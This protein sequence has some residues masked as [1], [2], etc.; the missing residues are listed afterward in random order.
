MT[1]DAAM[2]QVDPGGSAP[3]AED[4]RS[5]SLLWLRC[6]LA[7]WQWVIIAF[8]ASRLLIYMLIR[9]SRMILIR[10]EHWLR[11]GV[12]GI[13]TQESAARYLEIA[14]R[15][16]GKKRDVAPKLGLF[17]VY[18]KVVDFFSGIFASEALAGIVVSNAALLAAGILL[19]ELVA[20]EYK[21]ERLSRAAVAFLMFGPVSFF[22]SCAVPEALFLALVLAA[23]LAAVKGRWLIAS[24][25][26][27]V[28]SA[29]TGIGVLILI[30]LLHLYLGSGDSGAAETRGRPRRNGLFLA[31]VPLG[32][33]AFLLY[34]EVKYDKSSAP[35]ENAEMW[36]SGLL[37]PWQM[38]AALRA[39]PPFFG[40]FTAM[41]LGSAA[42]LWFAG[43]RWK[44]RPAYLIYGAIL[45]IACACTSDLPSI[46]R[47]L[48]VAFPLYIAAA[49][50][51]E[52]L[53]WAYEPLLTCSFTALA[54]CT[55]M[56]ANGH[57]AK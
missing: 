18:P 2:A 21:N 35:F 33:I 34:S 15:G 30:P 36:R 9:L 41:V 11:E 6:L 50:A 52:R 7:R 51:S 37:L 26:G 49:L 44:M 8:V 13:L 12:F 16:Y 43:L 39:L 25:C 5:A 40:Y 55:I 29:T 20:F 1:P 10:G 54:F 17:P 28:A 3:A 38:V 53:R 57:W 48:S 19:K 45:I 31:L 4:R 22:F 56:Y 24:L 27:M 42:V 47:Y 32:L 14:A 23:F 46:A